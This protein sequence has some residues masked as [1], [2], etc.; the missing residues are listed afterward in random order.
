LTNSVSHKLVTAILVV[1]TLVFSIT[2]VFLLFPIYG[3]PDALRRRDAFQTLQ[4]TA[5]SQ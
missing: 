1:T 5:I 2:T 3:S 4:F